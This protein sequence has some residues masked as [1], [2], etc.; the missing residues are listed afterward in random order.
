[1]SGRLGSD[2]EIVP[3]KIDPGKDHERDSTG[4]QGL[5]DKLRGDRRAGLG[6]MGDLA[7][8]GLAADIQRQDAE[9]HRPPDDK[10]DSDRSK[11]RH[12][13]FPLP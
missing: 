11:Q 3:T 13:R 8:F 6:S 4:D 10:I 5:A 1:M 2:V 9:Q 7:S 12:R